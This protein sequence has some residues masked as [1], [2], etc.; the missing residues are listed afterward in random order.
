MLRSVSGSLGIHEC[1]RNSKGVGRLRHKAE[2][3]YVL[4]SATRLDKGAFGSIDKAFLN[5]QPVAVKRISKVWPQHQIVSPI[6]LEIF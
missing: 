3:K 2:R 5:G 6:S 4:Q 1:D